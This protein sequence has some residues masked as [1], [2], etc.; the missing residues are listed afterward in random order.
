MGSALEKGQQG[1]A[2]VCKGSKK[3]SPDPRERD[4]GEVTSSEPRGLRENTR[5]LETGIAASGGGDAGGAGRIT[6]K[7]FPI[8]QVTQN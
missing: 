7:D 6:A 1:G 4:Q 3:G 8:R 5:A 2:S